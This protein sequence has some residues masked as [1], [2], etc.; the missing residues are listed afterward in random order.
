[1]EEERSAIHP[2]VRGQNLSAEALDI[3]LLP[4]S[5]TSGAVASLQRKADDRHKS[6][7]AAMSD[8]AAALEASVLKQ[9]EALSAQIGGM[10][11][12]WLHSKE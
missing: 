10:L 4:Y 7:E 8:A 12:V 5:A 6:A 3:A 1:M 11:Q 2:E 9:Q